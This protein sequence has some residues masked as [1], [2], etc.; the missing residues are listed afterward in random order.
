MKKVLLLF[1]L[2]VVAIGS[3]A[4]CAGGGSKESASEPTKTVTVEAAPVAPVETTPAEEAPVTTDDIVK[5]TDDAREATVP[6]E[7]VSQE[8]ARESAE[9]YL[10]FSAFS[11]SGLIDQ[12]KYEGFSKKDAAYAVDAI[13][14]DWNKQA[15]KSAKEYL[16]YSSFS[17]SG[18]IDQLEYEGFTHAQAVYGVSKTGL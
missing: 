14:P 2:G 4:A 13:S 11:R 7:T 3:I 15:V 5:I 10:D 12:L 1:V 9:S 16:D 17:R 6:V 8:N 18:L